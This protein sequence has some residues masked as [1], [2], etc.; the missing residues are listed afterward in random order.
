MLGSNFLT[1]LK[2]EL[3]FG[4]S[5]QH[6]VH[7]IE[8]KDEPMRCTAFLLVGVIGVAGCAGMPTQRGFEQVLKSYERADIN[9]ILS[10]L[11]PP[12][13]TDDLPNGNKMYTFA[14]SSTYTTP[15]YVAP[16][17]TAPS[18]TTIN[19]YGNTAYAT[20]TPG[21]TTGGQVYGGQ[22]IVS[23]CTV[24][25]TTDTSQRVIAWRYEG[26]QCRAVEGQ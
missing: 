7:K 18:Q 2:F 5:K 16:T 20:T 15:V 14:W 19:V 3:T 6:L 11:G 26:N 25:F 24:S 23:A 1:Q 9:V 12:T 4:S 13:R 17:R 10:K 21:R 8:H 22:T